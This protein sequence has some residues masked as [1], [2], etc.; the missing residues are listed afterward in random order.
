MEQHRYS[1]SMS[2]LTEIIM[3]SEEEKN[4]LLADE[5]EKFT[6]KR[7]EELFKEDRESL[8]KRFVD[9]T[10]ESQAMLDSARVLNYSALIY[11]CLN[12]ET[13]EPIFKSIDDIDKISDKRVIEKLL[14]EMSAF[15]TLEAPKEVRKVAAED[16]TFLANGESQKS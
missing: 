8:K 2:F 3:K 12:P 7:T 14:E 16:Q 5:I 4:K 9:L 15:R 6:K 11:M 10:I 13:H 1:I